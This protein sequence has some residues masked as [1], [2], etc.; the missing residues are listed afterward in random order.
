MEGMHRARHGVVG[1]GAPV[2]SLGTPPSQHLCVL[3][4]SGPF[5]LE[6]LHETFITKA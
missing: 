4:N 3:T 6:V 2:S 5:H 1:R